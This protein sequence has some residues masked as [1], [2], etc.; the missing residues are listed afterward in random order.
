MG[1]LAGRMGWGLLWCG[2]AVDHRPMTPRAHLKIGATMKNKGT[3][4]DA[5]LAL[6][7]GFGAVDVS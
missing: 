5:V 1:V 2:R 3:D 6:L 7:L 4:H